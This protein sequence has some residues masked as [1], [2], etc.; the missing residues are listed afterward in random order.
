MANIKNLDESGG[1]PDYEDLDLAFDDLLESEN[2]PTIFRKPTPSSIENDGELTGSKQRKDSLPDESSHDY[3]LGTLVVRVV[4]ARDLEPASKHSLGKMIFGGAHHSR[5]KGS[6][7]PYA[8]VRFGST[9]QRTSEVFD[10]VNPIWPRSETMYMDVS[11]PRIPD[12][13]TQQPKS[14]TVPSIVATTESS[15][16][17]YE[18]P[19]NPPQKPKASTT[20]ATHSIFEKE[21]A[22]SM[23]EINEAKDLYK[24]SRPI[25][26]V[27]IFHANEIGT[28]KKYN[29]SKGDSDDLFLGMVAIDLTPVLTG[30]TTIFDQWLPLTGTESTRTTVRIVCEYEASDTAP[31]SLDWV[32]FTRFCDPADFYP[33]HGDRLYKVESCDGDNVTLSWTSSEGWVSS[34][35]VHR[36]MLVCATRHQGPI[37]FY[38]DEIQSIAERLGHSPMVDT[39]QETLRTLPDEGLVS[40]SV[41]VFRGGTSLL[42]RWLDQGVRTIIDDIKF[43]T[44]IDGRHNPNFEDSLA[45]DTLDEASDSMSQAAFARHSVEKSEVESAMGTNLQPLPNMPACPITGEPMIDPVVAADG[46]TYERFAIARWLH[47]SDKSPLTGSILPHKSLVP[48][49]ML[50]SSLQ[51]CAVI[52]VEEDLPVGNDDGPLV[53]VVRDV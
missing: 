21:Q 23:L 30:K 7:N 29:P 44:N 31:Q 48:N 27:A 33:A 49:Y 39:V 40:V 38:Q 17:I 3:I 37:E 20:L 12:H 19:G 28:L 26:T 24:P 10:T 5:N 2:D 41:D 14:G 32:H 53:E 15:T 51:E 22:E 9:T 34:F 43:A 25:L 16:Q 46:H 35:V 1:I 47:E 4:A 11:H 36:N 6:A 8:S 45:T 50:V 13:A 42:N 52:S 18:Q